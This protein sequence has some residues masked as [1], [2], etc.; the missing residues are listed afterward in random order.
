M[1]DTAKLKRHEI[2]PA[3]EKLRDEIREIANSLYRRTTEKM[4]IPRHVVDGALS[5]VIAYKQSAQDAINCYH[6]SA[7]PGASLSLDKLANIRNHL[8]GMLYVLEGG[9]YAD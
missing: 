7:P 4:A 1:T 5:E 8:R 9:R 2:A 3:K 6:V